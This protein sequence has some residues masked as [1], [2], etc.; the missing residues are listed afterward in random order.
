M[1][2]MI[3][4]LIGGVVLAFFAY[5]ASRPND[6]RIERSQTIKAPPEAVFA[7]INNLHQFNSWNPFALV[8]PSL[9][10]VYIG[11]ESGAGAAYEWEGTGKSGKGRMEIAA[12]VPTSQ[13]TMRLEFMK[14]FAAKNMVEFTIIPVG[15]SS[16]VTWAMTGH[17]AYFQKVMSTLFKMDRVVGDQ[18][19]AGLSALKNLAERGSA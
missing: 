9:K 7:L 13:V 15:P 18:F 12:S 3:L 5:A 17:N 6:F 8:D 11:P 14:P 16:Q 10:I 19:A 4:I 1:L 2:R